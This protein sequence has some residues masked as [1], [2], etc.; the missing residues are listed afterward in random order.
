MLLTIRT[1]SNKPS[2]MDM[3]LHVPG[4]SIAGIK[5]SWW[6][7]SMSCT[8]LIYT[9]ST[10]FIMGVMISTLGRPVMMLGCMRKPSRIK[11]GRRKLASIGELTYATDRRDKIAMH[12]VFLDTPPIQRLTLV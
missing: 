2:S 11:L 3:M 1:W 6:I 9:S 10:P 8:T 12:S 5:I 7:V 4:I